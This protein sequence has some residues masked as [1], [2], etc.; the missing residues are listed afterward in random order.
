MTVEKQN[1]KGAAEQEPRIDMKR[2]EELM[3]LVKANLTTANRFRFNMSAQD[4]LNLLAACYRFAVEKRCGT[5][6]LDE[7][8]KC[9]LAHLA[10]YITRPKPK[11]GVMFCG[12]CGNGKTTMLY[13]L[14]RAI[15][16]LHERRHFSFLDEYFKVGMEIVDVRYILQI[17]NNDVKFDDLRRRDM[18][19]IDD[20]GKEP[21][22]IMNYG[23]ILNPVVDIIEHRYQ[24][25]LFTAI[26]TNLTSGQIRDKYGDRIAD[27]FNEMLELIVFQN[28]TYRH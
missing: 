5:L 8:T 12:T 1:Q 7:N 26:T 21:A 20:M 27:R 2:V 15:N 25:Q 4:A 17:A 16:L 9:C 13:A 11:F 3:S 6:I 24:N 14:Q 18:L 23:N 28:I 22:E 19:A 10:T